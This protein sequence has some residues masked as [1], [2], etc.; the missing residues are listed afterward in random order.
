MSNTKVDIIGAGGHAK[1]VIEIAELL[2]LSINKVY[3]CNPSIVK[4]LDYEVDHNFE[5]VALSNNLFFAIGNNKAR[6][7]NAKFYPQ[8]SK[9]LI[10]PNAVISRRVTLGVGNV[11]MAGVVINSNCTIGNYSIINTSAS[12]DH[13][14][15]VGDYVHISPMV[16]LAGG[17]HI[18]EGSHIGIGAIVNQQI[19]IGK[20]CTIGAGAV[21]INDVEDYAVVVGNPAKTIKINGE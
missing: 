19:T 4:V 5:K 8:C 7:E 10:H 20:W 6:Q 16:A 13:D 3:D 2:G 21:V 15:V 18:G 17:V 1:V 14:C 11:I 9:S 12:I